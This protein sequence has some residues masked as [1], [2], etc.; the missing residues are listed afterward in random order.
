MRPLLT[1][2]SITSAELNALDSR[3]GNRFGRF[4]VWDQFWARSAK[5]EK[6]VHG[7]AQPSGNGS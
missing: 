4:Y 1:A 5:I 3:D 2:R 7:A 6:I